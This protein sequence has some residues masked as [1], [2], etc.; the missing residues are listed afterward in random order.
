MEIQTSYRAGEELAP[1]DY[2]LKDNSPDN[3]T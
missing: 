2:C 1:L 3:Q